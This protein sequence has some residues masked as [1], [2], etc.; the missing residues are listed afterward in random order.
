LCLREREKESERE[1]VTMKIVSITGA[2]APLLCS[3]AGF[4]STTTVVV[5]AIEIGERI[6]KD[7][8]LHHGFPPENISLDE[9]LANKNVLLI[10]LPGAF[11]PT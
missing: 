1:R 10:G 7:L 9:R 11:T 8:T 5:D 2:L 4:T 3:L 6:P